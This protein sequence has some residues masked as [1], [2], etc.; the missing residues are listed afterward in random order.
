METADAKEL[1]ELRKDNRRLKGIMADKELNFK[2][3]EEV[4][5]GSF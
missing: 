5:K 3:L 4:Y 1:R 2:P